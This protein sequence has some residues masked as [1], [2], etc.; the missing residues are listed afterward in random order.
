MEPSKPL[1]GK[2]EYKWSDKGAFRRRLPLVVSSA[3]LRLVVQMR[4]DAATM[5]LSS[6]PCPSC[7]AVRFGD[8]P[9]VERKVLTKML[10]KSGSAGFEHTAIC[11]EEIG[12]MLSCFE[13]N[14]WST[15]TCTPEISRMETCVQMHKDDPVR[16]WPSCSLPVARMVELRWHALFRRATPCSAA[17]YHSSPFA[18]ALPT[19]S[20]V[21]DPRILARRW[22]GSIRQNVFQWFARQKISARLR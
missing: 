15:A 12:S 6:L 2:Q 16:T 11:T 4:L 8:L 19:R 5:H 21:Q 1:Q 20:L 3:I 9:K 13:A 14:A 7:P 17:L 10:D 22:Q 18:A